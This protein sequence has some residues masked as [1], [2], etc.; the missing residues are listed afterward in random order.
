MPGQKPQNISW[1]PVMV[2]VW[3]LDHCRKK[4][5]C[6]LE[7]KTRKQP[8][9]AQ[10]SMVSKPTLKPFWA[11]ITERFSRKNKTENNRFFMCS[12]WI[13]SLVKQMPGRCKGK[14]ET[15]LSCLL[16]GWEIRRFSGLLFAQN[17]YL[18]N[19]LSTGYYTK[20]CLKHLRF[21][22]FTTRSFNSIRVDIIGKY[23]GK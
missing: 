15:L 16:M 3:P 5:P 21:N 19:W 22:K 13:E 23:L 12:K 2:F 17:T 10:P 9:Q 4:R 6:A 1:L 7:I 18:S 20:W 14:L 8:S 11:C